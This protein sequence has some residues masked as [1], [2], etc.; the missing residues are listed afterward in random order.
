[1]KRSR[2]KE[3]VIDARI[4]VVELRSLLVADA[5]ISRSRRKRLID[6]CCLLIDSH[7]ERAVVTR[8][9]DDLVRSRLPRD[10][11]TYIPSLATSQALRLL[12]ELQNRTCRR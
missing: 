7:H 11:R 6:R 4:A 9:L 2:S 5:A 10:T 8:R 1:M 12:F 3:D